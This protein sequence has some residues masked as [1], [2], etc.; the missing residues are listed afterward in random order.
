MNVREAVRFSRTSH[1]PLVLAL[2]VLMSGCS[3]RT[4]IETPRLYANTPTPLFGQLA[5]ELRGDMLPVLFVTDRLPEP[6]ESGDG[7]TYGNQRSASSALGIAQVRIKREHAQ[8]DPGPI[9]AASTSPGAQP[10]IEV[11]SRTE[12]VRFPATPYLYRVGDNGQIKVD[13][14]VTRELQQTTAE[15]RKVILERLA[16]TPK[17]EVYVD[18][19]GVGTTFDA[20][21]LSMAE[22]WHYQGREGVPI[23]YTWPAGAKGL[24]FY[25][26][27]RESGEFTVLHLKHFLKFL[28]SIPE[29]E[30]INLAAHSRGNDVVMTALRELIIEARAKGLDP[31]KVLKI[32]NLVML[33]ADLDLEVEMQR[34]I[35][36]AMGPAFGRVTIYTNASD[37]ALAVASKLFSSRQRLGSLKTSELTE[38]E[39]EIVKRYVNLDIV[40]YEGSEGGLFRHN[41]FG[42][43]AV[44]SDLLMVLRYGWRPGEGQRRGLE[45]I[46]DNIWRIPTDYLAGDR[47]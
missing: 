17:K 8:G 32:K 10:E 31:Y 9:A 2:L 21:L 23:A 46:D 22:F 27:D 45:K 37:S 47:R 40:I 29:I 18:V 15:A 24:F 42:E 43:A 19:H 14:G 34:V 25:T 41:Y 4:M 39:R 5:P 30:R 12:L 6:D 3:T 35:G 26:V 11:A 20:A 16:L 33:A 7:F 13:S 36:E 44:S 38:R 28:A 1:L